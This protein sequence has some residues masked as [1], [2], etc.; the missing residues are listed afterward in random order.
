MKI[1]ESGE[2]VGL[3]MIAFTLAGMVAIIM[4]FLMRGMQDR[5]RSMYNE[6][7]QRAEVSAMRESFERRMEVLTSQLLS[8]EHRW[9]EVNH[10]L[11]SGQGVSN[12]QGEFP[13]ILPP[14]NSVF[15]VPNSLRKMGVK[16]ERVAV[17][18]KLVFVLTPFENEYSEDFEAIKDTCVN[19]GLKCVRGDEKQASGDILVHILGL[20]AQAGFVIANISSRN[21][22][23]YYELGIAHALGKPAILVSR[24]KAALGF[25]L[26]SQRVVLYKNTNDLSNQLKDMLLR[27]VLHTA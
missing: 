22:N 1:F 27:T 19:V 25:D 4:M 12:P 16:Q 9:K 10:L 5:S 8:T 26:Q 20:I 13:E 18:S 11:L 21:A 14:N 3:L 17:D 15:L 24:D 6:Q 23:V 7:K 2:I